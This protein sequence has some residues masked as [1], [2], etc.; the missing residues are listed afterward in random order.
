MIG[1]VGD[2]P[3]AERPMDYLSEGHGIRRVYVQW[4]W[5]ISWNILWY[6]QRAS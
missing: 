5:D 3:H 6:T 4:A 1:T 2:F